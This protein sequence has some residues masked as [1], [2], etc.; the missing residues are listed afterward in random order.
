MQLKEIK[1]GMLTITDFV[2]SIW[3]K[4]KQFIKA[5]YKIYKLYSFDICY[6]LTVHVNTPITRN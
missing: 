2:C 6:A 5:D 1:N 3:Y 4:E